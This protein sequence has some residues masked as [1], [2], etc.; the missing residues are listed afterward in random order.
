MKIRLATIADIP[1]IASMKKIED[2]DRYMQRINETT[3]GKS[4]YLV[5][6]QSNQ[7]IGQVFLKY[8]GTKKYSDYPN[9]EDLFVDEKFRG[10]GVGTTLIKECEN[11]A[12][13]KGFTMIGLSVNPS[14]N[15]KAMSLYE[16]LG[17]TSLGN[18]PYLDGVYNGVEDWVIDLVK[19]I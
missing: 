11:R 2:N 4:A 7:I 12:K 13:E 14:L 18:K 10:Q 5:A 19:A 3:D 1:A 9:M 17:Y 16:K 6:E 15:K 8:Y